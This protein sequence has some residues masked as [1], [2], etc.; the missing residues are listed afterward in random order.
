MTWEERWHPL[1]LEWVIVPAHRQSRP[2]GGE[3]V[4]RAAVPRPRSLC[5]CH[6]CP[7]NRRVSGARNPDYAD[8]FA[9]DNDHPCVVPHA[10]DVSE[11]S[12]GVFLR[13][14]AR[15]VHYELGAIP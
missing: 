14:P 12:R 4:P 15:G 11:D 3:T 9:F 1:R 5:D 8:V 2:W 7:T 10:P 6:L 13:R